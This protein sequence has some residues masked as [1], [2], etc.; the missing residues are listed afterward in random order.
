[1][2]SNRKTIWR[3]SRRAL[4]GGLATVSAGALLP[5]RPALAQA[6]GTKRFLVVHVPEGMW[7][8]AARPSAGAAS[9]G[10]IFSPLD[11]FK[12]QISF[13]D[14][15]DLR[16]RDNG[17]GGDGHHRGVPHL[18]TCTEMADASN[19]GGASVD[20][21]IASVI[22]GDTT[23]QSL[24]FAVRIVYGDTNAA[25]IWAGARDRLP[26]MQNPWEAYGRIFGSE[27]MDDEPPPVDLRKS[28]LDHA[29]AELNTLRTKLPA[30][31]RERLDSYQTSLRDIERRLANIPA[32]GSCVVPML[33]QE[34][35]DPRAESVYPDMGKLQMDLIVAALRCDVTRVASLQW[36]NSNDQCSYPWLGIN[37]L[38]HD[39]AHSNDS[40]NK[41]KVYYWYSEQFAY[42][43]GQMQAVPEGNGTLLDNTVILWVSEFSDSNGHRAD[44]LLW[45]LMGNAGGFFKQ[46][47]VLDLKGRS[48]NDVH[49]TVAQAFGITDATYGNPAYCDGVIAN[50]IA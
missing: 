5:R 28:A 12:A 43:L 44:D 29:L 8:G 16:S 32:P 6:S 30:S 9:F 20:Q 45:L 2:S 40:A 3:P 18:L 27:T 23:F 15:M 34:V 31:D 11:P 1:M 37:K 39:L 14:G 7:A 19:A 25:L 50:L 48:V 33:G 10:P 42:L 22:G 47:Q 36:G 26:A 13:L 41:Q 17:P 21:K 35:D 46:G 49:A 4:L 38:G 24:Q